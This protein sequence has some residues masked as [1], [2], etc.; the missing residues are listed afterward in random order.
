MINNLKNEGKE[1]TI[2]ELRC[3]Q[4][5]LRYDRQIAVLQAQKEHDVKIFEKR[6]EIILARLDKLD[7]RGVDTSE[8]RGMVDQLQVKINEL[9]GSY[10]NHISS[11]QQAQA[12][13]CDDWRDYR[14]TFLDLRGEHRNLINGKKREIQSHIRDI[15]KAIREALREYRNGDRNKNGNGNA[16]GNDDN[17]KVTICHIPAGNPSAKQTIEVDESAV[18]AHMAHGDTMGACEGDD[19]DDSHDNGQDKITQRRCATIAVGYDRLKAQAENQ[20]ENTVK[21]FEGRKETILARLDKLDEKGVD[22]SEPRAKLAEVDPLISQLS[23]EYSELISEIQEGKDQQ[24][25]VPEDYR[26]S[27]ANLR[28]KFRDLN[29]IKQDI[30]AKFREVNVSIQNDRQEWRQNN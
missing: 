14:D 4:W 27:L 26:E 25:S 24:C 21:I 6:Q 12:E 23:H 15:N 1:D 18:K 10:D 28:G 3:E 29:S 8:P 11:M 19:S 20:K 22:T 5:S 17:N 30:R 7:E 9:E 16:N 13:S 2:N